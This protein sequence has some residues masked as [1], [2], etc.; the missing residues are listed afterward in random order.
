MDRVTGPGYWTGL[1]VV[2]REGEASGSL[3]KREAVRPENAFGVGALERR[4]PLG[5]AQAERAVGVEVRVMR[6]VVALDRRRHQ[7]DQVLATI[8]VEKHR[9]GIADFGA[10]TI[11]VAWCSA[12]DQAA[13]VER[14]AV[15][16][17]FGLARLPK[18]HVEGA[19]GHLR[20]RTTVARR[21]LAALL[22]DAV[23]IH[24]QLVLLAHRQ[25]VVLL[26]I[27]KHQSANGVQIDGST[28]RDTFSIRVAD[29]GD[30]GHPRG[31]IEA[32]A[33]T[34]IS[35][36]TRPIFGTGSRNRCGVS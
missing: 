24:Q 22:E 35:E 17:R 2:H 28:H 6:A 11:Q 14:Q 31:R 20:H 12:H 18:R 25:F 30:G 5:G 4:P 3:Q 27:T 29:P 7:L 13:R 34:T 33:R 15:A 26:L 1:L 36:S 10:E 21:N 32:S 9:V 16:H 19:L 8:E 23:A